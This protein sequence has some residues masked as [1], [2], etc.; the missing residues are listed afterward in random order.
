MVTV[1][2]MSVAADQGGGRSAPGKF[3]VPEDIHY[4]VKTYRDGPHPR[5]GQ[6]GIAV[7]K[8][9]LAEDKKLPVVVFIHGGGWKNGDKDQLAWQC[10]RYAQD[11]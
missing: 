5:A 4:E 6:V 2:G 1:C 7:A 10:I 9:H 11:D 3:K 8:K